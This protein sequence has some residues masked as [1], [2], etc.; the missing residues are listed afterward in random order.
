MNRIILL[1][2]FS[3]LLYA[4]K[5]EEGC[6]DPL[7][8]NYNA[9]A[10]KDDG[11]CEYFITN[12]HTIVT[13]Y[14]FPDMIHPSD[15]L[16]TE[17]GIALGKYLFNS[18][19]LSHSE[20]LACTS[21]HLQEN[22]F[23]SPGNFSSNVNGVATN[24]NA[25]A[26]INL[27]WVN[28]LAWDGRSTGLE[29]KVLGSITNPFSIQGSSDSLKARA[30]KDEQ[31]MVLF[32]SAFNNES[33]TI[34]NAA[35]GLAQY[36]RTLVSANS[37]FDKYLNGEV[38]LSPSELGGYAT[39]NSEKGDCFHCHGTQQFSDNLFHNNGLD[40]EP[41]TDL[42][43]GAITGDAADFGKYRATTLRNI[44]HTAPYMHDGRFATLEEVVEHY[45]SGGTY[46]STIDPKMKKVGIGLQLTNQEKQDLVAFLKTLTDEN[47][48]TNTNI[49]P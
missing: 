36:I 18:P 3:T 41:F 29:A 9:E 44:E 6:T 48:L 2:I 14:G 47:F 26:L 10:E 38:Q 42:G 40:P 34:E 19:I 32:S 35:K 22:G 4:C 45:N 8:L 23:S 37:K 21:C 49:T 7:A 24:R 16:L 28:E 11:S 30:E 20:G 31:F 17:E 1:L 5:K 25:M 27:G 39:F 12:P 13:P 33:I 43:L 46:S 15:N